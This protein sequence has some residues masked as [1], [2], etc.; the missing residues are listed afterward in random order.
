VQNIFE[1]RPE[2]DAYR[3]KQE[4]LPYRPFRFSTQ[5]KVQQD[6]GDERKDPEA[7]K[8]V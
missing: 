8:T 4:G 6:D 3:K 5:G 2:E 1:Q 7:A